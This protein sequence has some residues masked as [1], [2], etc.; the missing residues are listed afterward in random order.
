MK[1]YKDIYAGK[2]Y[3]RDRLLHEYCKKHPVESFICKLIGVLALPAFWYLCYL[4]SKH[5]P[6][7][8]W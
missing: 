8:P 6:P 1:T 7:V 5:S 4:F 3:K 2:N